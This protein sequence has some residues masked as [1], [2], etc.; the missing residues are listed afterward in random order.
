LHGEPEGLVKFET[1]VDFSSAAKHVTEKGPNS[2][3]TVEE[4]LAVAKALVVL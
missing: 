2:D 1:C 3:E 4:A